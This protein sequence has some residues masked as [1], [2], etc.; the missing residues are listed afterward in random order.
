MSDPYLAIGAFSRASMLSIKMLRAYHEAGILVPASVDPRTGYRAYHPA[1][2]TDAA[3]IR[4]LRSLDLPLERVRE[5]LAARDPE[6]TREVLAEHARVMRKRLEETARIVAELQEGVE[7]PSEHTPVHLRDVPAGHTLAIRGEVR[8]DDFSAFLGPAY[9]ELG[10]LAKRLGLE[11]S[12]PSGALYPPEFPD[13][14]VEVEAYLPLAGPVSLPGER[15]RVLLGEIP[16]ARVAVAVHAGPYESIDGAYR[17]LGAWV[18]ENA[19]PGPGPVRE[20][21]LVSWDETPDPDGF[22][23]EIQWPVA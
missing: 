5:V 22:R 6:V 10:Q 13:D 15:G 20:V 16:A 3:V 8:H 19:E 4:R 1:Q 21:Y 9:A 12:G 18:A 14:P 7:R 2:L 23:T 11:P 17:R